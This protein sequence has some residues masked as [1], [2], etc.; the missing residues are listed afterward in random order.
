MAIHAYAFVKAAANE[1]HTIT[2]AVARTATALLASYSNDWP[3]TADDEGV[4]CLGCLLI[5]RMWQVGTVE[6]F[7]SLDQN[8]LGT[9]LV[10]LIYEK[11]SN[12]SGQ[13]GWPA[14][15][16]TLMLC[17][18]IVGCG[19]PIEQWAIASARDLLA[20]LAL[21]TGL[22]GSHAEDYNVIFV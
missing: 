17:R 2:F 3:F 11:D 22:P 4:D 13:P 1:V 5:R 10:P 6:E 15:L 18:N 21:A 20:E 7:V 19:V 8:F 12:A 9:I 14:T 16:N